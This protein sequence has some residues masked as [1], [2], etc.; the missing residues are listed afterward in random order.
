MLAYSYA[1]NHMKLHYQFSTWK[2]AKRPLENIWRSLY[3]M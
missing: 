1:T 3:F 2:C